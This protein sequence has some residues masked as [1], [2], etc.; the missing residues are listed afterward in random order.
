MNKQY[1]KIINNTV[2]EK[3][4]HLLLRT[5]LMSKS[6]G[7]VEFIILKRLSCIMRLI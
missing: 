1:T 6:S 5:D 4:T 7:I 3:R 2:L